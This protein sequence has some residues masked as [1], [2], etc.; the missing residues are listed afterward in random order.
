MV[1]PYGMQACDHAHRLWSLSN[2]H[3]RLAIREFGRGM[4]FV[5]ALSVGKY[6]VLLMQQYR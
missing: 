2:T 6:F 5:N 4:N 3:G 1:P